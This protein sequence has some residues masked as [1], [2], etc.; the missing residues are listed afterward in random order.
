M[1]LLYFRDGKFGEG[2]KQWMGKS[3]VRKI[4]A[5]KDEKI[6][7]LTLSARHRFVKM[8]EGFSRIEKLERQ[9]R[10]LIGLVVAQGVWIG[11]QILS[12]L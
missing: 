1:A 10:W 12:T 6:E 4:I 3:A 2:G 11:Y 5:A 9:R 7:E 8:H